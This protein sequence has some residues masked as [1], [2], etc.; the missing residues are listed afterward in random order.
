MKITGLHI[1][2]L[3]FTILLYSCEKPLPT[4]LK[5][6]N[7]EESANVAIEVLSDD[8]GQASFDN[9]YDTTG[10][11]SPF[12][13]ASTVV[14]FN[15]IKNTY[16]S[17]T[18]NV[19][20]ARAYFYDKSLPISSQ[21]KVMSYKT[22][23]M[24]VVAFGGKVAKLERNIIRF[25]MKG[26]IRDTVTG[27]YYSLKRWDDFGDDLQF[28]YGS[29]IN[30][31]V[32]GQGNNDYQQDILTPTEIK[33]RVEVAFEGTSRKYKLLWNGSGKGKIEI[34]IGGLNEQQKL[35]FPLYSI[36]A[37]DSGRLVI[38]K[39]L[40][41]KIPV[42]LFDRLS[43]S[44]IRKTEQSYDTQSVVKDIYIASQSIHS[45]QLDIN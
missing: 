24:G 19:I 42:E 20:T 2:P 12:R 4:E 11:I 18:S 28:N 3:F 27:P 17:K 25:R 26:Q 22:K 14:L 8:P 43:F 9:G 34:I 33:G 29:K 6:D 1:L 45:I 31:R 37:E 41:A 13:K 5:P 16:S 39:T 40:L 21:G 35:L 36:K 38:P 32:E 15:N 7:I 30:F 10:I 44:F 23:T